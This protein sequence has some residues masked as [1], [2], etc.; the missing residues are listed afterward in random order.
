MTTDN[1]K[2]SEYNKTVFDNLISKSTLITR[3][4]EKDRRKF[5]N[6]NKDFIEKQIKRME[7]IY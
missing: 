6:F 3:V 5:F 7:I 4:N 1:I 2:Y